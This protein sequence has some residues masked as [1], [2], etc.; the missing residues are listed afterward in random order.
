MDIKPIHNDVDYQRALME[1]ERLW[2]A[3]PRT[4]EGDKLDILV[5]LV[6]AY[7][8]SVE[9]IAPPDPVDALQYYL[10]SQGLNSSA[11]V[12]YIG[13]EDQVMAVLG[14]RLP[15]SLEMIRRLR[16]GL[17]ISADVLIQPYELEAA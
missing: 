1:I 10:E 17:G 3:D 9:P 7:E 12:P 16:Q 8:E 15:L 11:L 6:D 14:R 5:T 13:G 2:G 4:P